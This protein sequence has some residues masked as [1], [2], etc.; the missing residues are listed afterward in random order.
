MREK[1]GWLVGWL[2]GAK[3]HKAGESQTEAAAWL[4]LATWRSGVERSFMNCWMTTD[5]H[6]QAGGRGIPVARGCSQALSGAFWQCACCSPL[7]V[8]YHN[9]PKY[10]QTI[11]HDVGHGAAP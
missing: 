4:P 8:E 10:Q 9:E 11:T 1:S 6:Q 7:L 3:E 5:S 2:V